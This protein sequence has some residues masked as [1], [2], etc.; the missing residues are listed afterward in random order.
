LPDREVNSLDIRLFGGILS[1]IN[2]YRLMRRPQPSS[3]RIKQLRF[4][5]SLLVDQI[6]ELLVEAILGGQ[7]KG[8]DQLIENELQKQ[9][10]ISRSPIREAFRELEKRGL[11]VI[12][13]RRGTFVRTISR[14]DIE[15]TIPVRA[16]LEGLALKAGYRRI[17]AE[18]LSRAKTVLEKMRRAE[19]RKDYR[20]YWQDHV[21]YHDIFIN[22]SGND[23][24][25]SVL[26]PLRTKTMWYRFS[27]HQHQQD[28]TESLE[29]HQKLLDLFEARQAEEAEVEDFAR[30]H[31]EGFLTRY[32]QYLDKTG[33]SDDQE[34]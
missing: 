11:A 18:E 32:V 7:L 28:V 1:T 13:P 21:L 25:V 6:V 8:G 33:S 30:R 2:I 4:K 3:E 9:L 31:V 22:A 20:S 10:G 12:V 19:K 14:K 5:S 15:E 34:A 29:D 17:T 16:A 23:V 24:L 26:T 27:L